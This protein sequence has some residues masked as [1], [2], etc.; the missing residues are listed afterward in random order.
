VAS[1]QAAA[2]YEL[3]KSSVPWLRDSHLRRLHSISRGCTSRRGTRDTAE[4]PSETPWDERLEVQ[5]FSF[6][7]HIFLVRDGLRLDGPPI[8]QSVDWN[9]PGTCVYSGCSWRV[10]LSTRGSCE[11]VIVEIR[12]E[13]PRHEFPVRIYTRGAVRTRAAALERN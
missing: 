1:P 2:S 10:Q 13:A 7:R 11:E 3:L 6:T 12:P 8:S 5:L 9:D 4:N